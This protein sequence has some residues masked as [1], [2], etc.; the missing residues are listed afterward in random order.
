MHPG[1]VNRGVE[2]SGEV[3]DSPQAV[4]TAAGRGRGRR[5]HGGPL[6]GAG[7]RPRRATRRRPR[8][9]RS[10]HEPA[11]PARPAPPRPPAQP[12]CI[13]RRPRRSTRARASTAPHDVLVRDGEI[14]EIGAPGSLE[15]PTA[16]RSSTA[17]AATCSR[18]SSTRTCTCARRA[19]STRR[20]SRPAPAP[21]AAGGY[22]A[23]VAMPNTA[24]VDRLRAAP[25]LAAR[26][27][28]ARRAR[29]RR[30]H[31][32]RSRAAC[33]ARSS[34]RW[35]SCATQGA[36]GF[37]DDGRPVVDAGD[38]AQGAA[39]PAP[40]R[41]RARAARG[42]P[43]AVGRRRDARGRRSARCSASPGSRRSASRR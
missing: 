6:R 37:T 35:P 27:R 7:R 14:A 13:A 25:A 31:A 28:R 11:P 30:L 32:P 19:R 39:V 3:V 5:P 23:V 9:S 22:C 40:V 36:L 12:S 41:R 2:L 43:V 24:P 10:W 34:P 33:A 16:P 38:A 21:A 29:A 20:T 1:P 18:R 8:R 4:I 17:R 42:G 26:R 15:A